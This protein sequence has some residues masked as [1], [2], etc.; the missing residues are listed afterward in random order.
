MLDGEEVERFSPWNCGTIQ[1]TELKLKTISLDSGDV[2]IRLWVMKDNWITQ[3]G[4]KNI[5]SLKN[6]G[7]PRLVLHL[8]GRGWLRNGVLRKLP[9]IDH[10]LPWIIKEQLKF[11]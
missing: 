6:I 10:K 11:G 1:F 7:W 3:L 8:K 2:A 9:W 4:H 5:S